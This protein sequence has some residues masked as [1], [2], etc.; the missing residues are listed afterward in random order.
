MFGK[1][2]N[3]EKFVIFLISSTKSKDFSFY[4]HEIYFKFNLIFLINTDFQGNAYRGNN[5]NFSIIISTKNVMIFSRYIKNIFD[6]KYLFSVISH[7]NS[8]KKDFPKVYSN[9][10]IPDLTKTEIITSY[11]LNY[12]KIKVKVFYTSL[13]FW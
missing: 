4:F 6:L 3:T 11:T 1:N 10:L 13:I 7:G 12:I 9:I 8:I 2:G 5:F